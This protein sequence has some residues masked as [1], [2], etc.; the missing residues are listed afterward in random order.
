MTGG[1]DDTDVLIQDEAA[2]AQPD[3]VTESISFANSIGYE[4]ILMFV[5]SSVRFDLIHCMKKPSATQS[6]SVAR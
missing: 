5:G 2:D 4:R 3:F 6:S 1:Y